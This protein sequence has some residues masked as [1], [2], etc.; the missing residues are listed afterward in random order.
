MKLFSYNEKPY[1]HTSILHKIETKP[2]LRHATRKLINKSQFQSD[3]QIKSTYSFTTYAKTH[4]VV[5]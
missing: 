5:W 1:V 2:E 4:S 3:E